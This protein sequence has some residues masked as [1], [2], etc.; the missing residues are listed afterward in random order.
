MD[1]RQHITVPD[2]LMFH[3]PTVN[4]DMENRL[5]ND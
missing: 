1:T 3:L 5:T 4:E 2:I